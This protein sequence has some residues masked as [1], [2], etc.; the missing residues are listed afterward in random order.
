MSLLATILDKAGID[1][2]SGKIITVIGGNPRKGAH[3]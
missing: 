2:L 3:Y 1:I